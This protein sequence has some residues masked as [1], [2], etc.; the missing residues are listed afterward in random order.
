MKIGI[1][2][3][4][5]QLNYGG[6]LQCW[7]LVHALK[8]MGHE[9][10][11]MDRWLDEN[12]SRLLGP[13][14]TA[15]MRRWFNIIIHALLGCGHAGMLL[16]HWRT[17]RFIKTLGLSPYHFVEWKDAP[18]S[19]GIDCLVVGS[20]QVW[21]GGDW[22][23]PSHYLLEGAPSVSAVAYAASFG[24]KTL[25]TDI[26]YE[27]GFQRFSAIGVRESEGIK[28]VL[29]T[30]YLK[31]VA[32]VVDPTL[33][34]KAEVWDCLS[35]RKKSSRKLVCYFLAESVAKFLPVLEQWADQYDWHVDVLSDGYYKKVP[36]KLSEFAD[37]LYETASRRRVRICNSYGPLE[38]VRLFSCSNACIT[39]S[40]HAVMFSSIYHLNLRFIKPA[41]AW[42]MEMFSRIEEFYRIAVSGPFVAETVDTALS[43]IASGERVTFDDA[44]IE[45]HR[46]FSYDWL[47]GALEECE[48][49]R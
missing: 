38:F 2:T 12:N 18:R 5:S 31:K 37:R 8:K 44:A 48:S 10:I 27:N 25:P 41:A 9:V 15:D 32:H 34:V 11:V 6:V 13:F 20:D 39:D 17:C 7:A 29:D 4:H 14:A 1:L 21:H 43:S 45:T 40:F 28:L 36:T 33:L 19:L 30:G 47:K 22:G 42:R 35:K 16:R 49:F 26:N 46:Q 24:M 23:D 3:F